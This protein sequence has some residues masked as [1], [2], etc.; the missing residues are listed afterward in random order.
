MNIDIRT[1]ENAAS[2]LRIPRVILR[3]VELMDAE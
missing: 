1:D 2:R 3:D